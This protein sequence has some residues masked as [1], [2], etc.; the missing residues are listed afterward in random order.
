MSL[1][2]VLLNLWSPWVLQVGAGAQL[3]GWSWSLERCGLDMGSSRVGRGKESLAKHPILGPRGEPMLCLAHSAQ[4]GSII[5]TNPDNGLKHGEVRAGVV[6]GPGNLGMWPRT[7]L[8]LL[9][10]SETETPGLGLPVGSQPDS[11]GPGG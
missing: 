8:S 3:G 6:P 4:G 1:A 2:L 9:G 5:V 7:F 10:W 11:G